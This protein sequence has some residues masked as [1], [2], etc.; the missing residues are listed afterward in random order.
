MRYYSFEKLDVWQVSRTFTISIYK[1]TKKFPDSEKFGIVSQLRRAAISI[2]SNIAEGNSR[3]SSND[4]A[5]FFNIAYS[6][7]MEV[8]NQLIIS[9][10]LEFIKERELNEFRSVI[11][12]ITKKLNA[13][14]KKM[15][16]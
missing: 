1:S 13:L 14:H 6:S 9:A 12:E 10:D 3:L 15:I 11:N 8:L 7:V 2:C 4:K 5:R 16:R